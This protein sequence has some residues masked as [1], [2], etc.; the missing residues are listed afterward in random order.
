MSNKE[1]SNKELSNKELSRNVKK[2]I[3]CLALILILLTIDQIIKVSVKTNMALYD[4]IYNKKNRSYFE[5]LE[6][7]AEAIARKYDCRFID[8]ETP[9]ERVPQGHPTIVDYFYHEEVRGTANSGKRNKKT[10]TLFHEF[11]LT[12]K[13]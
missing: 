11:E 7:K 5:A 6:K 2:G 4:E 3:Y 9:Y 10:E 13:E 1:L 8:N 12:E